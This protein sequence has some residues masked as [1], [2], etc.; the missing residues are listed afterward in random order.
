MFTVG[1]GTMLAGISFM[2]SDRICAASAVGTRYP[3]SPSL[4]IFCPSVSAF[5]LS[6]NWAGLRAPTRALTKAREAL[7]ATA[8]TPSAFSAIKSGFILA[9]FT[10]TA[11]TCFSISVSL[12]DISSSF[13]RDSVFCASDSFRADSSALSAFISVSALSSPALLATFC[14]RAA[15]CFSISSIL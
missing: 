9:T 15:I 5:S 3:P 1:I 4:V 11:S 12:P 6:W 7:S 14:S 2:M 13:F 8:F 10:S